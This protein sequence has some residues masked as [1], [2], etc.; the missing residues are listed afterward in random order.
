MAPMGPSRKEVEIKLPFGSSEEAIR[1]LQQLGAVLTHPREFEDN[2][3]YDLP[4]GELRASGR[5]LRLRRAGQEAKVTFKSKVF[6]ETRH[7][8]RLEHETSVG[9]AHETEQIFQG[10]GLGVTYR[11][12]KYRS[13]YEL[14]SVEVSVDETPIGCFVELEGEPDAIDRLAERLGFKVEDY[15]QATYRDLHETNAASRGVPMG[16]LVF[17]DGET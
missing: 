1:R 15:I 7:K 13:V 5:I 14:A 9:S 6:R 8:V 11:Y 2:L 10:L 17:A 16:D 3:V 12:Q 4:S